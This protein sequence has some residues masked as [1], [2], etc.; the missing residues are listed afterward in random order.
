VFS[1]PIAMKKGRPGQLLTALLPPEQ[2]VL[3]GLRLYV[4][5]L[6]SKA[7]QGVQKAQ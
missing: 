2:D 5:D 3:G 7:W 6:A 4:K 1:Q